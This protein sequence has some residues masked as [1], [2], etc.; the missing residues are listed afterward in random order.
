LE[1]ET[2]LAHV[3]DAIVSSQRILNLKDNWDD[4]GSKAYNESTWRRATEFVREHTL[5]VWEH[6][7]VVVDAPRIT[8]GPE[9]SIDIHWEDANRELLVNIPADPTGRV[10]FYGDD[11]GETRIKGVLTGI[12]AEHGLLVW[13]TKAR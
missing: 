3:F 4:E 1:P 12:A 9:G 2:V 8:P 11:K 7:E 13:L 10:T 5:W 6:H